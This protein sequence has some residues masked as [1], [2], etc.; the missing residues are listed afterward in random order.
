MTAIH[1]PLRTKTGIKPS[2]LLSQLVRLNKKILVAQNT[3]HLPT[4]YTSTNENSPKPWDVPSEPMSLHKTPRP[5]MPLSKAH[6]STSPHSP[7]RSHNHRKRHSHTRR[8][9]HSVPPV[10]PRGR[11]SQMARMIQ[12][13]LPQRVRD[14]AWADW[15]MGPGS[16]RT[17]MEMSM[18]RRS[19]FD[20]VLK[21]VSRIFRRRAMRWA[22]PSGRVFPSCQ[23]ERRCHSARRRHHHYRR[24]RRNNRGTTAT[25][26]TP[27]QSRCHRTK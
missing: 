11:N 9:C 23:S 15:W 7:G 4:S 21:K 20:S 8:Q 5:P 10:L 3:Q 24:G 14:S 26:T 1:C 6:C 18:E 22:I 12:D 19:E 2:N 16:E 13:T 27:L 25:M 17:T